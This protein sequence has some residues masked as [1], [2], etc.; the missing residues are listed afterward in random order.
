M[1]NTI[2]RALCAFLMGTALA[3]SAQTNVPVA[4][5]AFT[6]DWQNL[7]SWDCPEWFKDAKFGI[8]AHWGPQCE[9]EA[10]D[11]Y[12]RGMYDEGSGQ[13]NYHVSKYGDPATFG[14]KD[15][16]NEWK[17]EEWNPDALIQLYKSVGARYFFTLGQH[18]DNFDLWNSPYQSWNSVNMG[19]KK[20]IVKGWSD[21]CKK[22]GLPLGISMHGSHAW[23]WYELAQDYDGNLTAADGAGKWWNGYDPQELYAQ[24]HTP[25]TNYESAGTIH[26]QWDWGNGASLPSEAYKMKFQNRVLEAVNTFSPD[27]LYFDDTVLP[28]YGCDES[29]G[30]NILS[31]FYNRSASQHGGQQQV[32][33]MGKKLNTSQ[34]KAML[35][36]VERGV[37]DRPQDDYW[38]TCT[39]I[40]SWHYDR[41]VYNNN[42][43]KSAQQVVD[44]LVDIVSKNGNL[45]LSVPI[46]GNGTI[47]EKELAVLEGIK[48]WMDVNAISIYGTR[49][50]KNFGEGPLAEASN[51]LNSQGFNESNN[52]TAK[53]VRFVQRNDT[54]FATILRWPAAGKF[55]FA[56]FSRTS[57]YFSG[58]VKHVSLLG[59]GDVTFENTID[60]LTV[61]V[62]A[63]TTNAIAPVFVITFDESTAGE[64]SLSEL[65]GLYEAKLDEIRPR[66]STNTGWWNRRAV[67]DFSAA[68]S[69]AKAVVGMGASAEQ[70]A[71]RTLATAYETLKAEGINAGTAPDATGAE[72]ITVD[73]LVEAS[74]FTASEMGSRFG[75]P[76]N[77]TVE[78]FTIPQKD[79]D[80]GVKNGIDAYGGTNCLMLGVWGGEDV[81]DYTSDITNARIYRKVHLMPGRYYFGAAYS[82]N[83]QLASAY[84]FASTELTT[85][86]ALPASALAFE[87]ISKAGISSTPRGITFTLDQEQDVYLGFQA[88]LASGSTGQ[89]FRAQSV[90]LLSYG[91]ADT[92]ALDALI[93]EVDAQLE[94]AKIS[95]NTGFFSPAAVA[96]LRAALNAAMEV[97]GSSSE[98]AIE[99]AYNALRDALVAFRNNGRN[100]GGLP[101][102][103]GATDISNG[104]FGETSAFS[105]ADASVTTRF[106]RPRDWTVEHFSIPNGSSGTKEGLDKYPGY[107]CLM[108]GIWDDRNQNQQGDLSQARIYR[109]VHLE[110]GRY[111]FGAEY[112]TTYA[113][114]DAAYIFA[115]ASLL[116]TEAITEDAIA[117]RRINLTADHS[118]NT[119]G[120]FF[121]IAEAGDYILGFQADLMQG[122][123]A[124]EF[125]VKSVTL[126]SYGLINYDKL[127]ELLIAI[128]EKVPTLKISEN[129]GHYSSTAF[130]ALQPVLE[131]ARA[132]QPTAS[133]DEIVDTYQTLSD[134]WADFLQN[135]R[136][137]ASQPDDIDAVDITLS[138]LPERSAF[139]RADPS[140]TTRFS[141]P[142]HWFVDN[143]GVVSNTEGIRNGLDKYPGD[144]YLSIGIWDD[145]QN[146][147]AESDLHNVR[148]YQNVQLPAGRY[149]FGSSYETIYNLFDAYVFV[150]EAP[151]ATSDIT[152]EAIAWKNI[153]TCGK[154]GKLWGV[155]F[156]LAEPTQLMLGWQANIA[157]GSGAQ[158]FRTTNITL[159][160][161]GNGEDPNAIIAPAADGTGSFDAAARI[162]Y[163]TLSGQRL[164]AAPAHG[165][166][167]MRQG[168][169]TL[170]VY[171]P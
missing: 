33:V 88:D 132:L 90:S 54:V 50:W 42:G 21:A 163:Y 130:A 105:R 116:T 167:I 106:S 13:Y 123:S 75:T 139:E 109:T 79:A 114:N 18:H 10:G 84:I 144:D 34:K 8:W 150:S 136:N 161:Y 17:A 65:I 12:A 119:E 28:F 133:F 124:Q 100:L 14:F 44:M 110:P 67:A 169:R 162:E 166:F 87:S 26:S 68:I 43:Y 31:H 24:N 6:P 16:I 64:Q 81:D 94:E 96:T 59:H 149:Y 157:E 122:G 140:V 86:D 77:W 22:Y 69:D 55:T 73:Q 107:D 99:D 49:P 118:T 76:A 120:I 165:L 155:Y 134:A 154:D 112:Q 9:A 40:G 113:I 85:T 104:I 36:D 142:R 168:T 92:E 93:M 74:A 146:A 95:N 158:E 137:V 39:C 126:L 143:Y 111:Y 45:L 70:R 117:F 121:D 5:G 60:G 171:K 35:W 15:V 72:D 48:A 101:K 148:I 115:S 66:I 23:T 46:R 3:A 62:P 63:N 108:L 20:D 7:S 135:G 164:G 128:D 19:P 53:D 82:A 32:V 91:V 147:P 153:N 25:S 41:S 151:L 57:K 61:D 125:R 103:E 29:V 152:A 1:N 127:A 160:S 52:Y 97:D 89:E 145:R 98:S 170:K 83:Y 56:S 102:M 2:R 38:Q 80:K 27:M 11:W 129:T 159:L 58:D 51:P 47:D 131:T 156:T 138:V 71:I 4:T 141:T 30:L 37:P 78:N